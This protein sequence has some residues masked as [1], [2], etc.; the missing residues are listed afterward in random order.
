MTITR[1]IVID[2]LPVYEAGEASADTRA[3]V[4][5][6][7]A[8]DSELA[9]IVRAARSK[10]AVPATRNTAAAPEGEREAV[11]RT[12]KALRR[13]GWTLA[14]AVFFTFVPFTFVFRGSELGFFMWRD[15]PGSRL[16]LLSAVYLWW[17]YYR[18]SQAFRQAG[19][20]R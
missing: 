20:G 16:L 15:E 8:Q 14:L 9:R 10:P 7:L 13:K 6:F 4:E 3:A 2:L 5:A 11:E 1:D 19:W 17:S 18:Q 12:R